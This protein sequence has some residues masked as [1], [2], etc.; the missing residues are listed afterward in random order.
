MRT[1]GKEGQGVQ[2]AKRLGFRRR[3]FSFFTN[4]RHSMNKL[5]YAVPLN[6]VTMAG[7]TP[8]IKQAISDCQQNQSMSKTSLM[9]TDGALPAVSRTRRQATPDTNAWCEGWGA[10]QGED[11]GQG[12]EVDSCCRLYGAQCAYEVAPLSSSYGLFNYRLTTVRHCDCDFRYF[13]SF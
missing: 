10:G 1:N 8:T 12:H 7:L 4:K 11:G 3:M 2:Q 9:D 6:D 5:S 13:Q